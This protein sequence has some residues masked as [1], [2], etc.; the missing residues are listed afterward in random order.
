MS[1]SRR[2]ALLLLAAVL[3][4]AALVACGGGAGVGL[5]GGTVTPPSLTITTMSLPDGVTGTAYSQTLQRTGGTGPF[6]WSLATGSGPLPDG[7]TLSGDGVISGKPTAVGSFS[8]TVQV[9]DSLTFS[10]V[11]GLTIRIG[12]PLMIKTTT[13]PDGAQGTAYSQTL[14]ATGGIAPL[15]WSVDSGMLPA[16]LTLAAGGTLSGTPTQSGNFDFTAKVV[17][18]SSPQQSAT[19]PL[20]IHIIP[21]LAIITAAL[22]DAVQ[23]QAYNFTLNASGGVTP[24]TW[25]LASGSLPTGVALSSSGQVSGIPTVTG[26]FTPTFR[27]VDSG[28]PQ[29]TATKQLTLR[30]RAPLAITTT[31]LPNGTEGVNYNQ[32]LTAS[33]G[34]LPLTWSIAA[35][36]LPDGLGLDPS[37]GAIAGTPLLRGTYNFTVQVVDSASPQQSA[38][39]ALSIVIDPGPLTITTTGLPNGTVNVAY[40]VFLQATGGNAPFTWSL[41]GGVLPGGLTLNPTTGEIS[42]T[43]TTAETQNFTVQVV[44]SSTPTPQTDS[45]ALSLTIGAAPSGRNDSIATATPLSNGAFVASISPYADPQSGPGNPDNDFYQLTANAGATVTV[46]ICAKRAGLSAPCL[47]T[48]ISGSALDSV[49]AIVD[50][51]GNAFTTCKDAGTVSGIDGSPDPTPTAFDDICINDDITLGT[52]Q[53][54]RLEF[55]VP[56]STGTVT[57]FVRVL[58]WR[59]DARPDMRYEI[60]ISGAN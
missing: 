22:D 54:S 56:G 55:R 46:E 4:A 37:T 20:S 40:S 30:V 11:R 43:P 50:L 14:A 2:Q 38:Q 16:G 48:P 7:L 59:G 57:F 53:D 10:A 34:L 36:A 45:Q 32:T 12:D 49:I 25:S 60:Q 18:S 31:S 8:F 33:G 42:G 9:V 27:V 19:Q 41:A 51:N 17:D 15:T 21:Q 47:S 35:G 5:G 52:I 3:L 26:D 28:N 39:K 58:D 1:R 44:D 13:L 24:Y 29:Q 23:N 6:T